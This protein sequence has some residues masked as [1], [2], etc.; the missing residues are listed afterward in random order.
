GWGLVGGRGVGWGGG[1][2]GGGVG[3]WG[4]LSAVGV[5]CAAC[6]VAEVT[7]TA[8]VAPMRV[9]GVTSHFDAEG[10]FGAVTVASF[11]TAEPVNMKRFLAAY[12]AVN[13]PM[14][15]EP[16]QELLTTEW[17]RQQ[18][19][20]LRG[21]TAD[22]SGAK[23]VAPGGL[24]QITA[25]DLRLDRQLLTAGADLPALA[26][27]MLKL[28]HNMRAALHIPDQLPEKVPPASGPGRNDAFG[29]LS[30]VLFNSPQ[31]YAPVKYGLVWNLDQRH[32]VH[33]DGNTQSPIG[34]NLLAAL[35][36]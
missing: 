20:N 14:G 31:P 3:A 9:L 35:G 10:Y 18:G 33:W 4:G 1:F 17:R 6:H 22:P 13:E 27:S 26:A 25:S 32:W 23:G 8:S 29:L 24:H 28:F 16:A 30:A 11:R 19:E 7:S 36:L 15:G 2:G 21:S 34:R 12:L 5:N